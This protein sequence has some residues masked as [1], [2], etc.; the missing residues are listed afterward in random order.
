MYKPEFMEVNSVK[1]LSE[2]TLEELWELFPIFLV[3]HN[4]KWAKDYSEMEVVLRDIFSDCHI[5]RISHIG[6][7]AIKDIYAKDIVDILVETD[8]IEKA[9]VIAERNG[10][11]RMSSSFKRV[12]LNRGYTPEGFADKVY[13]LHIR[14]EGDNNELYFRDY[15][16]DN[17]DVAEEYETL[18]LSLW[19]KYEHNRDEYTDAKS[20][21]VQKYTE[22]AKLLYINRY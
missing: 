22:K 16:N 4:E 10:F 1:P 2:M 17:P 8:D 5:I 21:F 13:H 11:I 7:T 15:L 14:Q 20:E 3:E 18:K 12:T 6:S 19:K 9:A